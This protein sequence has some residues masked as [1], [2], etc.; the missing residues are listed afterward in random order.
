VILER[1][2]ES[3]AV[4]ARY[5]RT[6]RPL[7]ELGQAEAFADTFSS[8]VKY[9][10]ELKSWTLWTGALWSPSNAGA[11]FQAV[12]LMLRTA[13][14]RAGDEGR[15]ADRLAFAKMEQTGKVLKILEAAKT[16][17]RLIRHLAEADTDPWT[18][19]TQNGVLDLRTG[20]L[21][22]H[23]SEAFHM[24]IAGTLYEPRDYPVFSQFIRDITRNRGSL[25]LW[26]AAFL[27]L[28]LTGDTSAQLF[29][30]FHGS[31]ANGKSVLVNLMRHILGDYFTTLRVE[32]L[33]EARTSSG[34]TPRTDLLN[35][36]GARFSVAT[37]G[38]E[39]ARLSGALVKSLSGEDAITA[40]GLYSLPVT[41]TPEAKVVFVTNHRPRIPRMDDAIRR[42][43]R[44]VPFDRVFSPEERDPEM[45]DKLKAEAP[46]ILAAL[47]AAAAAFWASGRG[48]RALPPCDEVEGASKAYAEGEDI[49][50]RFLADRCT[51][52]LLDT[53]SS[54]IFAAFKA[55]AEA[56]GERPY[57]VRAFRDAM[58]E[59]GH[60]ATR[61]SDGVYFKGVS[62]K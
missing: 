48:A 3:Q 36:R 28:C 16:E 56:E 1:T 7:R 23:T 12:K 58:E 57:S 39:G 22:P 18:I 44:L 50:A 13:G 46:A 4:A 54:D 51:A 11:E 34:D 62:L 52:S 47:A 53:R 33:L 41:F 21:S 2:R 15:A 35:L 20:K 6:E 49:L 45:L 30:V 14:I 31:G 60:A 24:K 55:W 27:G 32:T 25:G 29:T 43:L 8:V 5:I 9:I 19:N 37:E 38:E 42:R 17:P 26:L 59:R 61:K 40:R 10:P